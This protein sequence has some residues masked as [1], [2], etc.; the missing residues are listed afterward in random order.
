[1]TVT[2]AS[3]G[4]HGSLGSQDRLININI[5]IDATNYNTDALLLVC[6][7]PD[8]WIAKAIL[9]KFEPSGSRAGAVVQEAEVRRFDVQ[10]VWN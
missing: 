6:T 2:V 9:M 7:L 3:G 4:I 8:N 1:M 5:N 10:S